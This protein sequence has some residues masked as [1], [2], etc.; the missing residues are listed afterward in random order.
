M[1]K[2][3]LYLLF[4][5]FGYNLAAQTDTIYPIDVNQILTVSPNHTAGCE[6]YMIAPHD[7]FNL[8]DPVFRSALMIFDKNGESLFFKGLYGNSNQFFNFVFDFK[9]QPNGQLSFHNQAGADTKHYILDS[10][11]RV[12]D[13]VEVQLPY[14]SD[15][16]ELLL[17]A[18][19]YKYVMGYDYRTLNLDTL[20]AQG[21]LTMSKQTIVEGNVIFIYDANDNIVFQ[22][23]GF[24]YFDIGDMDYTNLTDTAF[25]DFM[26]ANSISLDDNGNLIVSLRNF[27]EV[28]KISRQDS[29]IMWRLGGKN[30]DFT[31]VGDSLG[32]FKLQH[33]ATLLPNGN[34][35]IL[36]N[37][38][39]HNPP[40][41]RALE[42]EL[43]ENNG[44]AT[45]VWEYKNNIESISVGS[46]QVLPNGNRLINWGADIDDF[47]S[48]I[49]EVTDNY[50]E[51]LNIDLPPGYFSYRAFCFDLPWQLQRPEITCN[52]ANNVVTLAADSGFAEYFWL[53]NN[54]L[55]QTVTINDTGSYQVF[56]H[57][58]YGWVGSKTLHVTD[59]GN[60]C[61]TATSINEILTSQIKLFP[62][63]T[64]GLLTIDLPAGMDMSQSTISVSN[65]LGQRV[66]EWNEAN[67]SITFST[68]QLPAG[69]YMV[70]IEGN[71]I[72]WQGKFMV[73]GQ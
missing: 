10:T 39:Y 23:N 32:G 61:D 35:T 43:D 58:G 49:V 45:L 65:T 3:L 48:P 8:V 19:G 54:T 18:D 13:S 15:A 73:L 66:L 14:Y 31:F 47:Y 38:T 20:T 28:V 22:W 70:H 26:H 11:L 2:T 16:H 72:Q 50:E 41:A 59:L 9:L 57:N 33:H 36:D 27:N 21:G 44:T 6:Y 17:T 12:V 69:T 7:G 1:K 30:S 46:H 53:H 55:S 56:G 64:N 24:D 4:I 52:I 63:P 40:V 60:P 34:V 37:G 62:N 5:A 42:Y 67:G 51:V 25:V 68:H 71:N 29:S